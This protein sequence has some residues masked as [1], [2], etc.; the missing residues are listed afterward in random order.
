MFI[1]HSLDFVSLFSLDF[2]KCPNSICENENIDGLTKIVEKLISWLL[3]WILVGVHQ[4][5][6]SAE[7]TEI[8]ARCHITANPDREI[9][10]IEVVGI[11]T[12][13]FRERK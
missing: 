12:P 9:F 2:F 7:R 4:L 11:W 3:R 5:T 8:E 1:E 6:N 13:L 10:T